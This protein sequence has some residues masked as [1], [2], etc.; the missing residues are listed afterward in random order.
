M[1]VMGHDPS[2]RA[3]QAGAWCLSIA[4][5][6]LTSEELAAFE[7]WL[8]ADAHN[9]AAFDK[10][11]F[12]WEALGSES[13]SSV[14]LDSRIDALQSLRDGPPRRPM[15]ADRWRWK[16]AAAASFVML[17]LASLLFLGDTTIAYETGIG[18]RRVAILSDGSRVSLDG[19]T[20]LKADFSPH[21]RELR[22][23][24]GR[25]K[26]DVARDPLRPFVVKAAGRSVVAVGTSFT[27][28]FVQGQL[29]V[30]LYE[31]NVA[32][33]HR[34]NHRAADQHR[35]RPQRA[36][37]ADRR[38]LPGRELVFS[39]QFPSGEVIRISD[40]A[41]SLAWEAGQLSFDDEPLA[42]VIERINRHT[43]I[44]FVVGDAAAARTRVSGVFNAGDADSFVEGI[45]GVFPISAQRRGSEIVLV[46]TVGP[47]NPREHVPQ[48]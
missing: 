14:L 46:A 45:T 30:A 8:G 28:E 25:A 34:G 17:L 1:T 6:P 23:L 29:R 36:E 15:I 2:A 22:L 20:R 40:P 43:A 42:M 47:R 24:A 48:S 38:L 16:A 10:A 13:A 39:P 32:V 3:E 18:E 7:A 5:G 27:V 19:A 35:L 26:F 4:E 37:R 21:R 44:Q 9:R 31:G 41:R 11:L 12:V 33:I